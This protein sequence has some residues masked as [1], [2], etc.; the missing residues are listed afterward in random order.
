MGLEIILSMLAFLIAM[1]ALWLT[2][3]TVKKVENQNEKFVRAHI[4]TLRE[5]MSGMENVLSKATHLAHNNEQEQITLN[6]RLGEQGVVVKALQDQMLLL[7]S[8]LEELDQSIPQRYRE[9]P[10]K[11]AP[12]EAS[13]PSAQ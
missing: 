8:K 6:Q 9:K 10:V 2:S 13:K 11:A 5:E 12:R 7:H 4:V 1:V 3:D